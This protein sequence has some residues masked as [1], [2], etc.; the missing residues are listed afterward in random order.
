M[1][2]KLASYNLQKI[3]CD[4]MDM[5]MM[6]MILYVLKPPFEQQ[7]NSVASKLWLSN[8]LVV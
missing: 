8:T 3:S 2:W 4:W 5:A 1:L 7:K 6:F